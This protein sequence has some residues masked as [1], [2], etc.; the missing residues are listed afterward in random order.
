MTLRFH[1]LGTLIDV[2][3]AAMRRRYGARIAPR[4]TAWLVELCGAEPSREGE[5]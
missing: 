3:E 5:A 4:A 2:V 1:T